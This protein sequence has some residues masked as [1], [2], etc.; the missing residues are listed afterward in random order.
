M[1]KCWR[2]RID[3]KLSGEAKVIVIYTISRVKT[4][5]LRLGMLIICVLIM[6]LICPWHAVEEEF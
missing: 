4:F 6:I 3:T 1:I 2:E 5:D